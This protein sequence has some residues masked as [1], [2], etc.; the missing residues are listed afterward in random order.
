MQLELTDALLEL[1]SIVMCKI[2]IY[3]TSIVVGQKATSQIAQHMVESWCGF[4]ML[5]TSVEAKMVAGNI[6]KAFSDFQRVFTH[7]RK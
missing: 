1:F 2:G 5:F 7:C 4:R 6:R 3:L